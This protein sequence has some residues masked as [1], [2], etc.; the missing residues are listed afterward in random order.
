MALAGLEFY[1]TQLSTWSS[2]ESSSLM[3]VQTQA[4]SQEMQLIPIF[5]L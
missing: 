2:P 4:Q 5:Y 3:A 1:A